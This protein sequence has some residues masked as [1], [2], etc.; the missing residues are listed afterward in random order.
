MLSIKQSKKY[1]KTIFIYYLLHYVKG[2]NYEATELGDT[3]LYLS[4]VKCRW[5]TSTFK[6]A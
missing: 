2:Y 3:D 6:N 4:I 5:S 1:V